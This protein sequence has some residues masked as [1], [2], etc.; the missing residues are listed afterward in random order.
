MISYVADK[1]LFMVSALAV[2]AVIGVRQVSL[3]WTGGGRRDWP[4]PHSNRWHLS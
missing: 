1:E 4:F 3:A 2:N